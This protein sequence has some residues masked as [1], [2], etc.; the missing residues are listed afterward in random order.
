MKAKIEN[1][2]HLQNKGVELTSEN[3]TEKL[4]LERL[5]NEH[6]RPVELSKNVDGSR[7]IVIAPSPEDKS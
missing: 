7:S 6:G 2:P 5:W 4:M 3:D 1:N